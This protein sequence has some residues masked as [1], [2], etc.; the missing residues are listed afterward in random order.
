[1]TMNK[2]EESVFFCTIQGRLMLS[3]LASDLYTILKVLL[4]LLVAPFELQ[5]QQPLF[6]RRSSPFFFLF[7]RVWMAS[8]IVIGLLVGMHDLVLGAGNAR[9]G[10]LHCGMD[11]E[12]L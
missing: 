6:L 5:T 2:R 10:R 8:V 9:E 3:D 7:G 4:V 12:S 11:A 1:V